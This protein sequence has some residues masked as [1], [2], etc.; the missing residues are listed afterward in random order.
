MG[1]T[2]I[3]NINRPLYK[4]EFVTIPKMKDF[5]SN[6]LEYK[7]TGY[8]DER[9]EPQYLSM[10]D[11]IKK[12]SLSKDDIEYLKGTTINKYNVERAII[13][14]TNN[15]YKFIGDT[16]TRVAIDTNFIQNSR[17]IHTHPY[18]LS[19]SNE[20]ISEIILHGGIEIFAFNDDYFYYFK[21][22]IENYAD[23]YEKMVIIVD[24]VNEML[25]K[26]VR[27]KVITQTQSNF[28]QPHLVWSK[29]SKEIKGFIYESY[30]TSTKSKR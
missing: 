12:Y 26:K 24:E 13:Y 27:S 11:I 22:D 21:N 23:Y 4:I 9:I 10:D 16:K 5:K 25:H 28:A 2:E 1:V 29:L 30:R 8:Y 17:I 19:F 20:D 18:G 15:K 3:F 6:Y 7:Q 14:T